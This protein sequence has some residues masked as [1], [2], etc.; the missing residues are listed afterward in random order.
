MIVPTSAPYA[1]AAG[2]AMLPDGRIVAVGG[3]GQSS[4]VENLRLSGAVVGY[5]G[6]TVAPWL[7][8]VGATYSYANAA[9]ARPT[10]RRPL[11]GRGDRAQRPPGHGA[12][13]DQRG[14]RP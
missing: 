13:A 10:A 4:A 9:V 14:G 2:G 3:S 6:D 8:P 12:R 11:G 5:S 7:R 1:Y